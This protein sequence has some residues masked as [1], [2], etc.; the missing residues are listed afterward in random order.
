M[1]T[2]A[3]SACVIF[4]TVPPSSS[5][6]LREVRATRRSFVFT[7]HHPGRA[8]ARDLHGENVAWRSSPV[9]EAGLPAPDPARA[10][11]PKQNRQV[12]ISGVPNDTGTRKKAI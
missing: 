4:H 8:L 7:A 11:A 9:I 2:A 1:S 10:I 3:L 6:S 12:R 5:T